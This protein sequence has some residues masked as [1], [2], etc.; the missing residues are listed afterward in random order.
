MDW[1][2]PLNE[3]RAR[4]GGKVALQGNMDPVALYA[5]P[6]TIRAKVKAILEQYGQGSGHVFNLGHGILPDVDPAHAGAMIAAVHEY[7]PA[8]HKA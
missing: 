3:A 5:S 4:V 6:E 8:F 1:T 7:S 2:T